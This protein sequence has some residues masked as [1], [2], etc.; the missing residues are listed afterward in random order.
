MYNKTS[1][2]QKFS[3]SQFNP[4]TMSCSNIL[5]PHSLNVWINQKKTGFELIWIQ[6]AT[7][8]ECID[9]TKNISNPVPQRDLRIVM[10]KMNG[11]HGQ[12]KDTGAYHQR[13]K[14][15]GIYTGIL[16]HTY[17]W[18]ERVYTRHQWIFLLH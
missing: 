1:S 2:T 3:Y 5:M 14:S 11:L 17:T 7:I 13:F 18:H 10:L 12:T 4:S 16:S 8:I 15:W 9:I 6:N